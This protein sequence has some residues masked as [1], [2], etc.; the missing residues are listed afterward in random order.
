VNNVLVTFWSWPIILWGIGCCDV[1]IA[2]F[3][4]I[5]EELIFEKKL[6]SVFDKN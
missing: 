1:L 2:M 4:L 5:Y 6:R 3:H